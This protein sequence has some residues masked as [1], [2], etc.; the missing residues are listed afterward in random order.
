MSTPAQEWQFDGLVGPTHNYAGLS[1]GNVASG[2]NAGAVSN[3]RQ[4]ARQGLEKMRFVQALG[5]QQA[6]LPPRYRPCISVLKQIGFVG[7]IA[8]IL[9]SASRLAP[10]LLASI[11]SS[12]FMW[13]AN[14]ATVCPSADSADGRMHLTPAN[15][16]TNF[17]RS[18]EGMETY[19]LLQRIFYDPQKFAVHLPLPATASLA[20][21]GAANHMRLVCNSHGEPGLQIFVYGAQTGA[22]EHGPKRFPARQ[23]RAAY[24]AIA[25]LHQLPVERSFFVQ[26]HPEAIDQGVFHNDVICMNTTRLMI[27]HELAFADAHSFIS[28]LSQA[29]APMDWQ[30]I[31]IREAELP[32][33]QAVKSY[34]FNSQLLQLPDGRIVIVAPAEAQENRQAE[35]VLQRL[36]AG[37]AI[38][39]VH[40]LDV[41]ESMRNGGGPACLRLRIVLTDAEAA[42]MHQGI[43]LTDERY[44][45]LN[46]WID[47]HYRDRLA[48]DDLRDP[49]FID[50]VNRAY[51]ELEPIL[52]LEGFYTDRM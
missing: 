22:V 12:S 37:N 5:M 23:Q 36:A 2:L 8:D 18:L 13:A 15:L 29:A 41:R 21:E 38:A 33:A 51:A 40:Y 4:A 50:E 3:P 35:A 19:D 52:G 6:I 34:F 43:V 11:Y 24:E 46:G 30:Y 39:G 31:E 17:H 16:L 9:Q 32:V 25:R 45:A 1:F 28:S 42:A 49:A 26:Q 27:G 20:D 7:G 48:F 44:H 10:H 47:R 14:A